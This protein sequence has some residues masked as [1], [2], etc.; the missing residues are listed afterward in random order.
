MIQRVDFEGSTTM[1]SWATWE[2]FQQVV[3][4][5]ESVKPPSYMGILYRVGD[6]D[7]T[8]WGQALSLSSHA[9]KQTAEHLQIFRPFFHSSSPPPP[10]DKHWL[11]LYIY[12]S[13]SV[14]FL[15]F[16]FFYIPHTN[17]YLSPTYFMEHN[18]FQINSCY[19]R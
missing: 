16:D 9:G 7:S 3:G 19:H 12:G 18:T 17:E 4:K 14:L 6:K 10:L 1:D 15:H 2:I 11:V 5:E 8:W 13:A